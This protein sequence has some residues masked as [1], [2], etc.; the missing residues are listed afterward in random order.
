MTFYKGSQQ[1]TWL[2]DHVPFV[3]LY[4]DMCRGERREE[5]ERILL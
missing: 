1:G 2:K 3:I 5:C 4:N